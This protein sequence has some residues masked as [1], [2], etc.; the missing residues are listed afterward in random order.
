MCSLG[1]LKILDTVF[2]L[3]SVGF[4]FLSH[5]LLKTFTLLLLSCLIVCLIKIVWLVR[6]NLK[7]ILLLI[8][9]LKI[10]K[11]LILLTHIDR[12]LK[13]TKKSLRSIFILLKSFLLL[14]RLFLIILV[15]KLFLILFW[16]LSFL[17]WLL[18]LL[19][20]RLKNGIL[21]LK[22]TILIGISSLICLIFE[23]WIIILKK[24]TVWLWFR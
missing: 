21:L 2:I 7:M 23:S 6:S 22:W 11:R 12:R 9:H 4:V 15:S 3:L 19:I 13:S 17:N 16:I 18:F 5:F 20:L 10:R 24:S 8:L 1:K 14:I